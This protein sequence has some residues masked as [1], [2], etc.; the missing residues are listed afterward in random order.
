MKYVEYQ[1]TR[2]H[3]T[4]DF[5]FAFYHITPSH[6]R[7]HMLHHW[8]PEFE[9]IRILSGSLILQ[10]DGTEYL[11]TAGDS[12]LLSGGTLHSAIPEF[13]HYECIVFDFNYFIKDKQ[14]CLPQLKSIADEESSL[15]FYYP[16]SQIK[17]NALFREIS[18]SLSSRQLGYE[19]HVQGAFYL[20]LSLNLY[21]STLEISNKTL[22]ARKKVK[23]FKTALTYIHRHYQEE[24]SLDRIADSVFMNPKYFCRFFKEFAHQTPMQY[25]NTYRIESACE[26]LSTSHK[27]ITEIAFECGFNDVGY[28]IKVFKKIKGITP[29]E[30]L[31][32]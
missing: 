6:P 26:K 8:H 12:F 4:F 27:S 32:V 21:H 23:Q 19:L 13:C 11:G 24:I 5:P 20:F 1:E 2:K 25:L 10:L 16:A 14:A 30:F 22:G 9:L 3:G 18:N 31:Q 15:P 7:Y 28:F 17:E 29:G